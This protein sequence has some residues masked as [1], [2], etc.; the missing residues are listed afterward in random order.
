MKDG[1]KKTDVAEAKILDPSLQLEW[2]RWE[3]KV[4]QTP[5]QRDD[6]SHSHVHVQPPPGKLREGSP[7]Q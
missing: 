4:E 7:N 3:V 1:G 6:M 2:E 5:H